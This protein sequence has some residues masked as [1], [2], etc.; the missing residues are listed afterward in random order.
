MKGPSVIRL[1]DEYT[2]HWPECLF[3][4]VFLLGMCDNDAQ[5]IM[6]LLI[7]LGGWISF[8]INSSGQVRNYEYF[9]HM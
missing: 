8:K 6:F 5:M 4:V 2:N 1:V 3:T 7:A 9:D